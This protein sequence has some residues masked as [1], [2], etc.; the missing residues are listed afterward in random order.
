MRKIREHILN[1]GTTKAL[2]GHENKKKEPEANRY[3]ELCNPFSWIS[4]SFPRLRQL[5]LADCVPSNLTI[6]S[7][8]LQ[9]VPSISTIRFLALD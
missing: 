6:R 8:G 9:F 5:G 1:H 2:K 3:I 4:N 7:P